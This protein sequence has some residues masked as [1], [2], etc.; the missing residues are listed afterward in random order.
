M[1]EHPAVAEARVIGKPDPVALEIVE[2]F[3]A[4]KPGV[5][6]SDALMRELLRFARVRLGANLEGT[7]PG[8]GTSVEAGGS[9]GFF[10]T[11]RWAIEME[12]WIPAYITLWTQI[13]RH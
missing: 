13:G 6:A 8:S 5:Q 7:D 12:A 3:V 10:F 2:A 1:L 9:F 11:E 4:L